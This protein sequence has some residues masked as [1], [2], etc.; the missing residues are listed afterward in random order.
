MR[1]HEVLL[2]NSNYE[3]LNVCDMRRAFTLLLLGKAD[4]LEHVTSPSFDW[5]L[6]ADRF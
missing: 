4:V 5:Q 1:G 3:P 6:N 2:L